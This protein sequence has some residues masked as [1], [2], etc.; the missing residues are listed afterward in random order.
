MRH[1]ILPIW[2][3]LGTLA[4]WL[5]QGAT[6]ETIYGKDLAWKLATPGEIRRV[7]NIRARLRKED[8]DAEPLF[9]LAPPPFEEIKA[10]PNLMGNTPVKPKSW[11]LPP[12]PSVDP[13]IPADLPEATREMLAARQKGQTADVWSELGPA[14]DQEPSILLRPRSVPVD[15]QIVVRANEIPPPFSLRRYYDSKEIFIEVAAFGGTTSFNA[16]K[17]FRAMKEAATRQ[18]SLEGVG[19]EAFLT[20]VE[21]FKEEEEEVLPFDELAPVGE[22]RPDLMD[23]GVAEAMLAPAFQ[24]VPVKDLEGVRISFADPSK[25]VYRKDGP[26]VLQSV[27]VIVAFFPDHALTVSISLEERLGTVQDLVAVA[28]LV[29]RKINNEIKRG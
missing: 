28:M 11:E 4:L 5:S 18:K 3:F 10:A 9:V 26:E 19:Q 2:L 23:S 16:E 20:R 21:V 15:Q 6:A 24:D 1:S 25:K 17:A 12:W 13:P 29:Q 8:K 22:Q 14:G 7:T 27:L